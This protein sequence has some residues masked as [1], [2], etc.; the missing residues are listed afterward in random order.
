MSHIITHIIIITIIVI[1]II[2]KYRNINIYGGAPSSRGA[3]DQLKSTST[4]PIPVFIMPNQRK[5]R[6]EYDCYSTNTCLW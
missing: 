3:F 4:E 5:L 2:I 1:V 6:K